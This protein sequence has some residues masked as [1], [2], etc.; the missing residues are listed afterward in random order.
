M[1]YLA[2]GSF[3]LSSSSLISAAISFALALAFANLFTKDAYGTYKYTLTLF[4]I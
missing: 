4:G 2:H 1:V 3:W